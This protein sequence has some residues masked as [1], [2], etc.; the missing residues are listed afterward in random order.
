M[1]EETYTVTVQP[2]SKK[3][4]AKATVAALII[5]AALLV[6]AVLP[7]DYGID[8]LGTGKLLRLTDLAKVDAKIPDRPAASVSESKLDYTPATIG[9]LLVP[10]SYWGTPTVKVTV[11]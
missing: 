5:A 8:P 9:L 1:T 3:R 6:T 2:P 7:A 10:A 4:I 11:I